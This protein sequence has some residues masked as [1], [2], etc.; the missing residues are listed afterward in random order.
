ME[1]C[2]YLYLCICVYTYNDMDIYLVA[3]PVRKPNKRLESSDNLAKKKYI[4][5]GR[6]EKTQNGR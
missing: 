3:P 4:R 1:K 5:L 2:I 6:S